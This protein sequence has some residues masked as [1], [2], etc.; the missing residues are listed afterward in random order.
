MSQMFWTWLSKT[1]VSSIPTDTWPD[2]HPGRA[3][4][5]MQ[6]THKT[7]TF[8]VKAHNLLNTSGTNGHFLGLT[9]FQ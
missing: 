3:F 8:A 2:P 6:K 1:R 9:K 4:T 7:C 5:R